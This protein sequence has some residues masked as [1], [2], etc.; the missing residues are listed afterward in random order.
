MR[1]IIILII[2]FTLNSCAFKYNSVLVN[3]NGM[4]SKSWEDDVFLE[5]QRDILMAHGNHRYA[6]KQKKKNISVVAVKITNDSYET[7]EL[8]KTY[9]LLADGQPVKV[10]SPYET[11]SKIKQK[12]GI[13]LLY[14]LMTPINGQN[15]YNGSSTFIPV[16]VILGPALTLSNTAK[17]G[18]A[19]KMFMNDLVYHSIENKEILPGQTIY[20]LIAVDNY[21]FEKLEIQLIH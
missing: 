16:G 3:D 7:M 1:H 18:K 15:Y 4:S 9:R 10:L 17:A 8:G 6:E 21:G 19:N 11:A 2:F 12:K 20:G 5:Y 14:L 13:Y